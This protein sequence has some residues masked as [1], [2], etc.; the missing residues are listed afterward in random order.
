[1][2]A[3]NHNGKAKIQLVCAQY[4]LMAPLQA[5]ALALHTMCP[6]SRWSSQPIL[7]D[8]T[9]PFFPHR[10]ARRIPA[11]GKQKALLRATGDGRGIRASIGLRSE[12]TR[13]GDGDGGSRSD[14]PRPGRSPSCFY[15]AI[16]PGQGSPMRR[17]AYFSTLLVNRSI[18]C[19]RDKICS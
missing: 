11:R 9:S 16:L 19:G 10:R 8:T 5:A 7:S 12:R 15:L 14:K 6:N 1:V 17:L 3:E 2:W 4:F 13:D 18:W